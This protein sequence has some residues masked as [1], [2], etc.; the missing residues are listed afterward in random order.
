MADK[1]VDESKNSMAEI[2]NKVKSVKNRV[3]KMPSYPTVRAVD[4][5]FDVISEYV[6]DME[7]YETDDG[8]RRRRYE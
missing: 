8:R 1:I 7:S 5:P 4:L 6:S 2:A 3:K